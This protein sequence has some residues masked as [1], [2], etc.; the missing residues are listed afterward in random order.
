[1]KK[2]KS[3]LMAIMLLFT[4]SFLVACG[5]EKNIPVDYV[6]LNYVTYTMIVGSTFQLEA[7]VVPAEATDKTVKFRSNDT[8]VAIVLSDGTVRAVGVGQTQI[9]AASNDGKIEENCL[10]TVVAEGQKLEYPF[11]VQYNKLSSSL[12]WDEVSADI[13]NYHASYEVE[14][15]VDGQVN[16][17]QTLLSSFAEIGEGKAIP[18]G[19]EVTIRVKAKGDN[20][21]YTDSEYSPTYKLTIQSAPSE[22]PTILNNQIIVPAVEGVNLSQ[23]DLIVQTNNGG[24][25]GQITD[26]EKEKFGSP[27]EVIVSDKRYIGWTIPNDLLAGTYSYK[28]YVK[29]DESRNIFNSAYVESETTVTKLEAPVLL[30]DYAQKVVSVTDYE[31]KDIELTITYGTQSQKVMLENGQY[32]LGDLS[33]GTY[34]IVARSL[35]REGE[36]ELSS[37]E[38]NSI[39]VIQLPQV[40]FESIVQE[41]SDGKYYVTF[42]TQPQITYTLS[43]FDGEHE[44]DLNYDGASYGN[45]DDKSSHIKGENL[46]LL[47]PVAENE[48]KER[49]FVSSAESHDLPEDPPEGSRYAE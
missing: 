42:E 11:N 7:E 6:N 48:K 44:Y 10:V 5:E 31:G 9:F 14:V 22:K 12:T 43:Y 36:L 20:I 23:Y 16:T 18:T 8:N 41:V 39:D 4:G 27:S 24:V 37:D 2:L 15:T 45:A 32:T 28:V 34:T 25:L 47:F 21:Y 35:A 40:D 30:F 29:G 38:S 13:N 3:F 1:M 46:S 19:K 33:A 26:A 49:R 17:Y